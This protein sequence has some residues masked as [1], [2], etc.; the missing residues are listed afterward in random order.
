MAHHSQLPLSDALARHVSAMGYERLPDSTVHATRRVL[1]DAVGVMHAAS[2]LASEAQPFIDMAV[3]GG[4]AGSSRIW[5]TSHCSTPALAALANGALSH[6]LDYE[7]AFDLAPV[8]PNASLVPAVLALA[9][10]LGLRNL[11]EVIAAVA[12]GCDVACRLALSLRQ[13]LETGGWYPP[14]ILG[15]FGAVAGCA[16][17]LGLSPQQVRDALSLML[18]QVSCPGEIKYS[19]GTVLRA[20][21]EAFPAQAA[22][23]CALLA[24]SGV[25]GLEQPLEGQAGFYRLFANGQYAPQHLLDGLG[26]HWFIEQLSF[27][28]WPSCRGTHGSI[29]AAL[30]LRERIGAPA[31]DIVAVLIEGCAVQRMLAEPTARKQAPLTAIDAK[32]SL[33]FT[34]AQALHH[35]RVDLDSFG[36]RRLHDP[37]VLALAARSS[38]RLREGWNNDHMASGAVWLQLANGQTAH[39]EVVQPLGSPAR[40]LDDTQLIRKFVD[41]CGRAARPMDEQ[42][43]A[44]LAHH[45]LNTDADEASPLLAV[46]PQPA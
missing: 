41:C 46:T 45:I 25:A 4:P 34:C 5:G 2:G 16:R 14:P 38:F 13:P 10:S 7:D 24:R 44:A 30:W 9:Q 33:A 15:A 22:V 6:A 18:M 3:A 28:P 29:E 19:A 8:H 26:E 12:V 35:G 43:A 21:R 23:Q 42:D 20:V 37:D 1:L 32:F 36:H 40:P 31:R 27:K 17:L 39:H 11:R